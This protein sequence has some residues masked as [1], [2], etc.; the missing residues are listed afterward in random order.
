MVRAI[1][2]RTSIR[3]Y[4]KRPVEEEKITMILKAAMASP[5]TANQQP[6]EFVV[7]ENRE[8]IRKLSECSPFASFVKDAPAVIVPCTRCREEVRLYDWVNIDLSIACENILLEADELGLGAAWCGIAPL[9]ERVRAVDEVLH[10]PAR[11]HS[12]ALIPIGYPAEEKTQ[13]DRFEESRIHYIR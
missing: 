1:F 10:L 2:H 11:L 3:K 12:F 5:S 9:E 6:W 13:Q 7:V 4:Q 8:V